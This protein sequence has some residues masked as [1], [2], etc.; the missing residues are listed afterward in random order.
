MKLRDHPLMPPDRFRTWPPSLLC[1]YGTNKA[2]EQDEI[3]ILTR[4]SFHARGKSQIM[5]GMKNG[6]GEYSAWVYFDDYQSCLKAYERLR[7]SIGKSIEE[8]GDLEL[9]I[10]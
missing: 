5:V 4:V 3:D 8:V 7:D 9:D 2:I 1:V 6:N 10:V